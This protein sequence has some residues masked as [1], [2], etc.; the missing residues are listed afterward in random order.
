[1]CRRRCAT[2]WFRCSKRASSHRLAAQGKG[3]RAD[4]G[5]AGRRRGARR[6]RSQPICEIE[7]ELKAGQPDA[8]FA[9][10]LEWAAAVR[11]PAVRCQQGRARRAPGARRGGGAGEVRAAGARPR[12]ERGRRLRRDRARRV[13]RSSRPICRGCSGDPP[14]I[15]LSP[16]SRLRGDAGQVALSPRKRERE[17][18]LM[19]TRLMNTCIRRGWRCGGCARRCGFTAGSCVLPDELLDGLRALAAALGPARDWDVLCDET[20]P[21]IAPHYPT[22]RRLAARHAGAAGASRRGACGDAGGDCPGAPGRVAAGVAA[23]AAAARLAD[24]PEAQRFVQLS[25]LRRLGAP[26]AAKRP[27]PH[28]A[29]RARFRRSCRRRSATPCASPSSASAMRPSFSRRCSATGT[30]AARRATWRCCATRRTAWAAATMRALRGL[31]AGGVA[32]GRGADGRFRARLAGGET[33]GGSE[34]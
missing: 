32:G 10:A 15:P 16:T 17:R 27:S 34:R 8:L 23:L 14:P 7:L 13:L 1:M 3:R 20:L 9:L 33:G 19:P 25:P 24:A 22:M 30:S 12:H 11:L 18:T 5:G 6:R 21:A 28:R 2:S 29:R 31:A 26:G 4:R